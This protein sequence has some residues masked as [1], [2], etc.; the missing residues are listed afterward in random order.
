MKLMFKYISA[1]LLILFFHQYGYTQI[2]NDSAIQVGTGSNSNTD[3]DY[4]TEGVEAYNNNE[5]RRALEYLN[6]YEKQLGWT[7][8]GSYWKIM[9]ADKLLHYNDINNPIFTQLNQEINKFIQYTNTQDSATRDMYAEHYQNVI[10]IDEKVNFAILRLKWDNDATYQKALKAFEANTYGAAKIDAEEAAKSQNGNALLLLGQIYESGWTGNPKD[11]KKAMQY[12]QK[13]YLAGSNYAA[14]HIG[15]LYFHGLGILKN[16]NLA[17]QWCKIA[18]EYKYVPAMKEI[19]NMYK[20]GLGVK[21]DLEAYN[22]WKT[23]AEN[24]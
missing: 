12:Y 4:F 5:F 14:Y 2:D 19:A 15:Y 6:T 8:S 10:K 20:H 16:I 21:K 17:F 22:Y 23:L 1:F 7:S 18:A 9:S 24:K 11:Y 3:I 13:A